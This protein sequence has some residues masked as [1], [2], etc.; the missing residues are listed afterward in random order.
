MKGNIYLRIW[1]NF[2]DFL[3]LKPT[4]DLKKA[5]CNGH[6]G[7]YIVVN[8]LKLNTGLLRMQDEQ[9]LPLE[10]K[11]FKLCNILGSVKE[12]KYFKNCL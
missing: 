10:K 1:Y 9:T 5:C 6:S 4:S 3:T 8:L 12:K 2:N 11:N 7:A